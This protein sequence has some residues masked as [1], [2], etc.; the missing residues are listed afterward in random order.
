MVIYIIDL[1]HLVCCACMCMCMC[2]YVCVCVCAF[3]VRTFSPVPTLWDPKGEIKLHV[4][5][6]GRSKNGQSKL[7]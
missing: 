6:P 7:K 2:V 1:H 5:Y 3:G 4:V